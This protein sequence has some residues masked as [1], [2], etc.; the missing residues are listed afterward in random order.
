MSSDY[1]P[2]S[3]DAVLSR[4]LQRLDEQDK[5]SEA[6]TTRFLNVLGDIRDQTTKTNGRVTSLERWR[7]EVRSKVAVIAIIVSGTGTAIAWAAEHFFW[8]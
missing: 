7:T 2:Q 5:A 8:K 3:T 4:I 1:N 6:N